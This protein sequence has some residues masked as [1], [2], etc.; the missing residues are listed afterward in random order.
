M[1]TG[2]R[3]GPRTCIPRT[4]PAPGV[5]G[6]EGAM[7]LDLEDR[8]YGVH[9]KRIETFYLREGEQERG[10]ASGVNPVLDP[11]LRTPLGRCGD[12]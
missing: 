11:A 3:R 9:I 8:E 4:G 6:T 2:G 12:T 10:R 5:S 7:W 1:S